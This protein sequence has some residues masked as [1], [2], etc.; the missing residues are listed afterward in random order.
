MEYELIRSRRKTAVLRITPE[1]KLEVRAPMRYPVGRLEEFL[2]SKREW[3][4]QKQ[5]EALSRAA[6]RERFA[7]EIGGTS[8][9]LGRK[10]PIWEGEK[11]EFSGD[12]FYVSPQKAVKPQL[13]QIYREQARKDILRRVEKFSGRVGVSPL[14]VRINGASTRFGSCSGENR[15]NFSWKIIL[16]E[17]ELVDYVVV[18]ELC[19]ILEHNHSAR[20]W[21]QVE[22][23]VPD[24]RERQERL[25]T[26]G[27]M[28]LEQNWE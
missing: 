12:A 25:K 14:S 22:R 23:N 10:Y 3:I 8:L 1:G 13:I 21:K 27:K 2:E 9:L 19:H 28:L 11:A 15:L 17:P 18:H 20:F 16:S 6:A 24:Y 4:E 5:Q 26:F 7:P